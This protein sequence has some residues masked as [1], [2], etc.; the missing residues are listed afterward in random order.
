[1][2]THE[3]S[4]HK[5]QEHSRR[6][7]ERYRARSSGSKSSDNKKRGHRGN[8]LFDNLIA[9]LFDR[10]EWL[11]SMRDSLEREAKERGEKLIIGIIFLIAGLTF[12]SLTIGALL[13]LGV[14]V[15]NAFVDNW[16][17]SI[18]VAASVS[19][20]F[21]LVF[22]GLMAKSFSKATRFESRKNRYRL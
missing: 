20:L 1:M 16:I 13:I 19:L 8:P 14:V 12:L 5:E 3:S 4:S 17:I 2:E 10:S 18:G 21:T 6:T 11:R 15:L 7:G 9:F 22:F